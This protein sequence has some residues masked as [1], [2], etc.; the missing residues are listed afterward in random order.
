MKCSPLP[1]SAF[2]LF[3]LLRRILDQTTKIAATI[4]NTAA[5]AR[6][7]TNT[8]LGL[9]APLAGT[10]D[11]NM[12]S[13]IVPSAAAAPAPA[14]AAGPFVAV[15]GKPLESNDLGASEAL[16]WIVTNTGKPRS[17][18]RVTTSGP[19]ANDEPDAGEEGYCAGVG[20]Y[21]GYQKRVSIAGNDTI[22]KRKR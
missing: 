4:C 18:Q 22:E 17:S 12:N 14:V 8:A 11:G 6:S 19:E 20:W 10:A 1:Y 2:G 5:R 3:C 7:L 21:F 9:G 15:I 16:G 13:E